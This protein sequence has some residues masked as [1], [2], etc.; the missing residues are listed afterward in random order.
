MNQAE[1]GRVVAVSNLTEF[2]R[3]AEAFAQ[4]AADLPLPVYALGGLCRDDMA[5]AQAAGAQ[6]VAAIRAAWTY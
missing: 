1:T 2:F 5:A 3:D 6:G 4:L